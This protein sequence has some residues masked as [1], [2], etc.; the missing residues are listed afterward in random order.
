MT[1]EFSVV[2][3]DIENF[4]Q[5]STVFMSGKDLSKNINVCNPGGR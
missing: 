4:V 2:D 3:Q 1:A 5:L